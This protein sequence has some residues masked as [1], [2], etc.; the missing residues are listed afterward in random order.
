MRNRIRYIILSIT[1]AF[2]LVGLLPYKIPQFNI[3]NKNE[4][5]IYSPECTCCPEFYIE[6]GVLEI[7]KKFKHALPSKV[8]EITIEN[9]H[10]IKKLNWNLLKVGNRFVITGTVVGVDSVGANPNVPCN[11]KAIVRIDEWSPNRYNV[12]LLSYD[13]KWLIPYS[14]TG[15]ILIVLSIIALLWKKK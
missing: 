12:N 2:L 5:L 13:T 14:V 4:L 9:G 3:K 7:P 6:E 10:E 11:V 1:I 8:H 15:S